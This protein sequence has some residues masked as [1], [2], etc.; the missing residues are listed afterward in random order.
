MRGARWLVAGVGGIA[1]YLV[2]GVV[3]HEVVW[4]LPPPD[5]ANLPA[6]GETF[7]SEVEGV[8]QTVLRREAGQLWTEV[9]VAPGGDGPPYHYHVGFDEQFTVVAGRLRI[10]VDDEERVLGPGESIFVPRG[11]PHTFRGV[12]DVPVV[13]REDEGAGLPEAFA[14]CLTQLY[15]FLDDEPTPGLAGV[16]LQLS[17]MRDRCDTHMADGPPLPVERAILTLLAPTARLLG[18][19]NDYAKYAPRN[20]EPPR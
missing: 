12:G 4:P 11:V 5:P 7:W 3:L 8:Q 18:Y 2:G 19:R 10:V 16:L 6:V 20:R 1:A 14:G 9:V 17:L 13:V 15:G